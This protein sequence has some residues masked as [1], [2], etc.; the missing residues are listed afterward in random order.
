MLIFGGNVLKAYIPILE[1]PSPHLFKTTN[2]N[3]TKTSYLKEKAG[4]T[5]SLAK[6]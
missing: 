5:S 6:F 4:F 2:K 1:N 3:H